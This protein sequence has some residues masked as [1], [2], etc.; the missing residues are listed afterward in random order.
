[1]KDTPLKE[2][3]KKCFK[4]MLEEKH[5][6]I[7]YGDTLTFGMQFLDEQGNVLTDY[8]FIETIHKDEL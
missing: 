8:D 4:Q 1:M 7:K 3:G 5:Q 6:N 2:Y